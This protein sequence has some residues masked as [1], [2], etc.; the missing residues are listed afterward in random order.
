MTNAIMDT[1]GTGQSSSIDNL[2]ATSDFAADWNDELVAAGGSR[3]GWIGSNQVNPHFNWGQAI[4]HQQPWGSAV[5][6]RAR[7]QLYRTPTTNPNAMR[8]TIPA[9]PTPGDLAAAERYA[10]IVDAHRFWNPQSVTDPGFQRAMAQASEIRKRLDDLNFEGRPTGKVRRGS[11]IGG[12]DRPAVSPNGSS[13]P[14]LARLGGDG[15]FANARQGRRVQSPGDHDFGTVGGYPVIN[16]RQ[17]GPRGNGLYQTVALDADTNVIVNPVRNTDVPQAVRS[18]H[19]DQPRWFRA[20]LD[21]ESVGFEEVV[22]YAPDA[23]TAVRQVADEAEARGLINAETPTEAAPAPQP[24]AVKPTDIPDDLL[25]P[26]DTVDDASVGDRRKPAEKRADE[27]RAIWGKTDPETISPRLRKALSNGDFKSAKDVVAFQK[28]VV[29][30]RGWTEDDIDLV[31]QALTDIRAAQKSTMAPLA[32]KT[33]FLIGDHKEFLDLAERLARVNDAIRVHESI[34]RSA[35][36]SKD[37]KAAA[38]AKLTQLKEDVQTLRKGLGWDDPSKARPNR[39]LQTEGEAEAKS[40]LE[41]LRPGDK[42]QQKYLA[43]LKKVQSLEFGDMPSNNLTVDHNQMVR[44]HGAI[45]TDDEIAVLTRHAFDDG[46]TFLD[47]WN[48]YLT[49]VRGN[50]NVTIRAEGDDVQ[51]ALAL[52]MRDYET[53]IKTIYPVRD[54]PPILKQIATYTRY[55]REKIL[56]SWLSAP[57]YIGTQAAGNPVL[58]S[59]GG[60]GD[61]ETI[62]TMYAGIRRSWQETHD[63]HKLVGGDI[64]DTSRAVMNADLI[65][66]RWGTSRAPEV[67]RHVS[68]GT[69]LS[70]EHGVVEGYFRRHNIPGARL[71]AGVFGDT[72]VIRMAAAFDMAARDAVYA[73]AFN[74]QVKTTITEFRIQTNKLLMDTGMSRAEA[75]GVMNTFRQKHKAGFTSNDVRDFFRL[76]LPDGKAE[77]LARDWQAMVNDTTKHARGEVTRV[78]FAGKETNLDAALKSVLMFHYFMSRQYFYTIRQALHHP[79]LLNAYARFNEMMG[80][81]YDENQESIPT[82]LQGFMRY[83]IAG[84]G[85]MA[86]FINPTSLISVGNIFGDPDIDFGDDKNWLQSMLEKGGDWVFFTP[87]ITDTLNVLGYLKDDRNVDPLRLQ[88]EVETFNLATNWGIQKGWIRGLEPRLSNPIID[89]GNYL[90]SKFSQ[91]MPGAEDVAFVSSA[92]GEMRQVQN[93]VIDEAK[94]AGIDPDTAEGQAQINA[95]LDDPTDPIYKAGFSRYLWGETWTAV[96]RITPFVASLRP[97]V[98]AINAKGQDLLT[99]TTSEERRLGNTT[100]EQA[101]GLRSQEQSYYAIGDTR[102]ANV[103]DLIYNDVA[104]SENVFF[105][106]TVDGKTYTHGEIEKMDSEERSALA[107][108]WLSEHGLYRTWQKTKDQQDQFL[109]QPENA[110]FATYKRWS[111]EVRDYPG[112]IEAYWK[113]VGKENENAQQYLDNLDEKLPPEQREQALTSKWAY[114]AVRGVPIGWTQNADGEWYATSDYKS[115]APKPTN[116]Y[117][118]VNIANNAPSPTPYE[119]YESEYNQKLVKDLD[120]Y[121]KYRARDEEVL[122]GIYADWGMSPD[123]RLGV[124]DYKTRKALEKEFKARTGDSITSPS[125]A[126]RDYFEWRDENP[127]RSL[128]DYIEWSDKQYIRGLPE[129]FTEEQARP[130]GDARESDA[131]NLWDKDEYRGD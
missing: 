68:S 63:M 67:R 72:R 109:A 120:N 127:N 103:A 64:F 8:Q 45:L 90:R 44:F 112:G 41:R 33:D 130:E 108:A 13:D 57:R 117:D 53:L 31:L 77:R 3:V 100:D 5:S 38:R 119:P 52:A 37:A 106:V 70:K 58:M 99:N 96:A 75:V 91:V 84:P 73:A 42:R 29:E 60:Y 105:D 16:E 111:G 110:D 30:K 20:I 62:T 88:R 12:G 40:V 94:K 15:G 6:R 36:I 92:E 34:L 23:Y 21:D 35:D 85:G 125:P 126:V 95:I 104:Y 81:Y 124:V 121:Q 82:W 116:G 80:E 83:A 24:E 55:L 27:V 89:G 39:R 49:E 19:G 56:G 79:G 65:A 28:N 101:R 74:R 113:Q 50:R 118:P 46:D 17:G 9:N 107:R 61:P 123:T 86:L 2:L 47:R 78:L 131:Y 4:I 114:L 10:D 98:R 18:Q 122:Q 1:L 129:A 7:N 97:Q 76:Y 22:R 54:L 93:L 26:D 102:T 32:S 14:S 69:D 11:L 115:P 59:L 48:R 128:A 51:T 71:A 87:L 66:H 43:S 25:S